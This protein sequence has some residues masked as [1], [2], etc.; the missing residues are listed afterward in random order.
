VTPGRPFAARALSARDAVTQIKRH[1]LP[2]Y[3]GPILVIAPR[4]ANLARAQ[5][6]TTVAI[7]FPPAMENLNPSP[8]SPRRPDRLPSKRIVP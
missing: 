7:S 4:V 2:I 3:I 6:V 1:D 8:R 5:N